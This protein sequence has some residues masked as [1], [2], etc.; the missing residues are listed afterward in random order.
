MVLTDSTIKKFLSETDIIA[1]RSGGPG[2]Q[3]VNKVNSK[4][5][6]RFSVTLSEFLNDNQKQRILVKL[7]NRINNDGIL[8]LT[9]Q[10]ERTQRSNKQKVISRFTDLLKRALIPPKR[11]IK[12][13][14]TQAS[15]LKR[16][17][18]KRKHSEKKRLRRKNY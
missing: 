1:S 8:I 10:S 17:E 6:L 7:K 13:K 16:L 15:K 11:R 18:N 14:P 3:N 4:V 9:S 12:T 5:E 2:G